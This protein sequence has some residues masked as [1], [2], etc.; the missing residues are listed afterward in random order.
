MFDDINDDFTGYACSHCDHVGVDVTRNRVCGSDCY[1]CP[2]CR[3]AMSHDIDC[4]ESSACVP[5]SCGACGL[6]VRACHLTT[7][8][9][10]CHRH[11]SDS[12]PTC[13][14]KERGAA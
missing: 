10:L 6:V 12:C 3:E 7:V 13:D 5:K 14:A 1:T 11:R 8:G 2:T 9:D 4:D